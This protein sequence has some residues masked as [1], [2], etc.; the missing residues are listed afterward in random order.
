MFNLMK[1]KAFGTI[2]ISIFLLLISSTLT[3]AVN[4]PQVEIGNIT[5]IKGQRVNQLIGY[6][7]VVGLNGSGDSN[8]SQATVQSVANML[9]NFGVN[10]TDNQ[11]ASQNIA[12]VMVTAE[13][14][15]VAHNGD[16]IDITVSSIGDADSLQGGT[17]LLTPLQAPNGEVYASAQGPLSVGGY[18]V[19][20]SSNS[21]QQNHPTVGRIPGGALVEKEINSSL[22]KNQLTY[23]LANPNFKT[24]SQITT[25]I[26]NN[27]GQGTAR[28]LNDST[29]Q[30]S[31]PANFNQG[32]VNFIAQVNSL[33]VTPAVEARVVIDEKTGTV[34]FSHNVQISTVAVAHGNLSV[35]I[36]TQENVSQPPP[37]SPGETTVTEDV[38]IK[39]DEGQQGNM[40]VVSQE[41]TIEDL[42]TA[43]NAIGATPRD[44][45]SIIQKIDAAGALHAE[46]I[47]Q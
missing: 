2:F 20:G 22:D 40:M 34:V 9:Q 33:K 1:S 42:V 12:A 21:E 29:I 4:D 15:P 30:I 47:I 5:R 8:R 43:L 31:K 32:M 38:K 36:S 16:P 35:S 13:L 6:G 41:N 44:I 14:P 37:L 28:A 45:I 17:L 27:F 11:V 19:G 26:N 23:V 7:I 25:T 24:A 10:V 18:S 39:V 46:L 3:A